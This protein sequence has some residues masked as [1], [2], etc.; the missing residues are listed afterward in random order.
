[1]TVD[2]SLHC[3]D[4][5]A[6]RLLFLIPSDVLADG[7]AS[8]FIELV[9]VT[10]E[11]KLVMVDYTQSTVKMLSWERPDVSEDTLASGLTSMW[12]LVQLS[13]GIIAV[14]SR[15]S[16]DIHLIKVN[17]SKLEPVKKINIE[18]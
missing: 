16:R 5:D 10:A 13:D 12:S 14:T 9:I 3:L 8:S 15:W 18:K 4:D 17:G 6:P 11:W 2:H 1:M 7:R